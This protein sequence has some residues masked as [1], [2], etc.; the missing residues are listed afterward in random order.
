[1]L[2]PRDKE[3]YLRHLDDW[4][5]DVAEALAREE[6]IALGEA[7]WE[8]I[9][10]IRGFYAT[11]E[12]SPVMRVLVKRAREELGED[13]GTSLYLLK[14]FPGSPAKVLA[15]IAGLPRPTNCL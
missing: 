8:L 6:G 5:E 11:H 14:L 2:P 13:K 10:M 9:R 1:M 15:K 12:V 3:G 7:H 4:N